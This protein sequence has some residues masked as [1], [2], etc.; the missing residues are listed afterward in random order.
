MSI[1]MKLGARR[2]GA[3]AAILAAVVAGPLAAH[4]AHAA[5]GDLTCLA[6]FQINFSS[7]LTATNTTADASIN[8]GLTNCTSPNGKYPNLKSGNFTG[9]GT[10]TS[11]G[12]PCDLILTINL[13]KNTA[14]WS[15]TGE[16]SVAAGTVSTNPSSGTLGINAV[17]TNGALKGD[18]ITGV[19]E[20]N[21]NVDC[22][23]NGLTSLSSVNQAIFS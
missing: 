16:H 3:T 18:S 8:G 1:T 23:V 19:G 15:P 12:G 14:V 22:A 5:V 17:V 11:S 21:P 7:P 4:P 6:N 10:A 2:L 13:P 20:A 9:K